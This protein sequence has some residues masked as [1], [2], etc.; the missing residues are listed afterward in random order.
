MR[1]SY[2]YGDRVHYNGQLLTVKRANKRW[3]VLTDEK[4]NRETYVFDLSLGRIV[5]ADQYISGF[6]VNPDTKAIYDLFEKLKDGRVK[7]RFNTS[8]KIA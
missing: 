7:F 1:N 3:A 4:R 8:K 2:K 5:R 6:S